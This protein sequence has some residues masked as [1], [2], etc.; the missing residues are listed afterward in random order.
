MPRRVSIVVWVRGDDGWE[1]EPPR[2]EAGRGRQDGTMPNAA[3]PGA[4]L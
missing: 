1:A 3:A 4:C 2:V